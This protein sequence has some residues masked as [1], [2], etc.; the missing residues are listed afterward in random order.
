M[1]E[2]GDIVTSLEGNWGGLIIEV[3]SF[4][5]GRISGK[6]LKT[7]KRPRQQASFKKPADKYL[8]PFSGRWE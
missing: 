8:S 3:I 2:P 7:P 6:V 5:P 4:S 1:F